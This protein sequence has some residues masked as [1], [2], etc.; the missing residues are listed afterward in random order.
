MMHHCPNA[1]MQQCAKGPEGKT[2][3]GILQKSFNSFHHPALRA[4][5][6]NDALAL[7]RGTPTSKDH[8]K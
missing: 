3:L 2:A 5:A 1:A 7:A 6:L 4:F 8:V